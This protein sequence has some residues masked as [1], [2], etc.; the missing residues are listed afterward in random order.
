M[1]TSLPPAPHNEPPPPPSSSV[2]PSLG[3]LLKHAR[4]RCGFTVE[5]VAYETKIPQRHLEALERDDLAALPSGVYLRGEV[6]AYAKAVHLDPETAVARLERADEPVVS[7]RAT[8]PERPPRGTP[9]AR[10]IILG[11]GL[12][13]AGVA[14]VAAI[15]KRESLFD[16]PPDG[17][18]VAPAQQDQRQRLPESGGAAVTPTEGAAPV[19][20][21]RASAAGAVEDA[22]SDDPAAAAQLTITTEPEGAWVTVNGIGW[23][24]TPVTIQHVSPG[25]KRIRVSADGFVAVERV[26]NLTDRQSGKISIR[27]RPVAEEPGETPK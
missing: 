8:V 11:I 26:V 7:P 17:D 12:T 13:L 20:S 4:E 1:A 6:R 2:D 21:D 23:G 9:K 3:E 16:G 25:Q 19:P 27:L 10:P 14:I 18:G 5:Q 24:T 15:W 22:E